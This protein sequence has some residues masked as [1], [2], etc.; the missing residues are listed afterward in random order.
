M[1]DDTWQTTLIKK[2][3]YCTTN[4]YNA[5]LIKTSPCL[6]QARPHP[7]SKGEGGVETL[8]SIDSRGFV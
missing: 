8:T 7:L 5:L 4:N 2:D 6:R 3:H 1:S